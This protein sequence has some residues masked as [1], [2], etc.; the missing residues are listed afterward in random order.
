MKR[1]LILTILFV[2]TCAAGP[3]VAQIKPQPSAAD[4][5]RPVRLACAPRELFRGDTLRLEMGVPHGRDLSVIG[6]GDDYYFLKSWEPEDKE[7]T[8]EW[9]A[10]ERQPTL[11]LPTLTTVGEWAGVGDP[12]WERVFN[13]TGWYEVRISYNL[14]TDDGT[15]FQTCRVHYT[16]RERTVGAG[17][18]LAASEVRGADQLEAA[19]GQYEQLGRD[20]AVART[21]ADDEAEREVGDKIRTGAKDEVET[22]AEYNARNWKSARLLA[23]ARARREQSLSKDLAEADRRQREIL[24]RRYVA[25]INTFLD[26]YNADLGAFTLIVDDPEDPVFILPIPRDEARELKANLDGAVF[27][28]VYRLSA[29]PPSPRPTPR[30]VAVRVTSSGKVYE[31]AT[32]AGTLLPARKAIFLYRPEPGYTET[33]RQKNV[34]GTVRLRMLLRADGTAKVLRVVKGLPEGLTEKAVEAAEQVKFKPAERDGRPVSSVVIL[35]YNF[36][37]Y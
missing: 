3:A 20:L 28:G 4:V 35:D 37:I 1:R 9:F 11:D 8:A 16:D 24:A 12:R 21:R 6:P 29:T 34:S 26:P 19:L 32:R 17:A 14:E 2:I 31:T 22:I 7:A 33:A 10:F 36:N 30:L 15:P 13:K 23:E 25:K 18:P 5:R 27:E